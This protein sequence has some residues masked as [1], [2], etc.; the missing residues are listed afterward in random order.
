MLLYQREGGDN[1]GV[2]HHHGRGQPG[3][4]DL[5]GEEGRPQAEPGQR[6]GQP[7]AGVSL[8][9]RQR[10]DRGEQDGPAKPQGDRVPPT[11]PEQCLVGRPC[12]LRAARPRAAARE[13]AGS[14][15]PTDSSCRLHWTSMRRDHVRER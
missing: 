4:P 9:G 14:C 12:F 2:G 3:P 13:E 8:G 1:R 7:Q 5:P 10:G 11:Q 15:A 6:G